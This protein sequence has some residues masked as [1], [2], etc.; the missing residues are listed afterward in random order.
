MKMGLF[1]VSKKSNFFSTT[2][3]LAQK[4]F[5]ERHDSMNANGSVFNQPHNQRQAMLQDP[6]A[7]AVMQATV[8]LVNTQKRLGLTLTI[9]DRNLNK[10]CGKFQ[11]MVDLLR[12]PEFISR[13]SQEFYASINNETTWFK[14]K[15][16]SGKLK[17]I[18]FLL[19]LKVNWFYIIN[20][21]NYGYDFLIVGYTPGEG[22]VAP[23]T[24]TI[25]K[26]DVTPGKVA[27]YF[28][29]LVGQTA[30]DLK[31][32]GKLICY[33]LSKFITD[34]EPSMLEY[35]GNKQG[36]IK[37][38]NNQIQFN[39]PHLIR[40][41]M[42]PYMPVGVTSRQFPACGQYHN[43]VDMTPVFAP[44][45]AGKKEFQL[46][47]L[48]RLG[49]WHQSFFARKD[50]YS[51]NILITKPTPRIP[52]DLLVALLKNTRYDSLD[53]NT[54]ETNI[55]GSL[56]TMK[57][58]LTLF[59]SLI[60]CVSLAGCSD[61]TDTALQPSSP[62]A[63]STNV[64]STAPPSAE[65]SSASTT[66]SS[67]SENI[68]TEPS[69]EIT[70]DTPLLPADSTFS[71]HFIDVG[72]ADA[73]LVECDGHYMLIDGGNKADSSVIYTVLRNAGVPKLDIVVGTH[74][75]EDHIG[76]LPG[77]Y[78]D[79]YLAS[80]GQ[81]VSITSDKSASKEDILTPGGIVVTPPPATQDDVPT[82][83]TEYIVN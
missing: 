19:T 2:F 52:R 30:N 32:I 13:L 82:A 73:A 16:K 9:F 55:Y 41:G 71:I 36:F 11:N 10:I 68:V 48:Y 81:T 24:T 50:I 60:L 35:Y 4:I 5:L 34:P 57:R 61:T 39:P 65:A 21:T 45:F 80:D 49:S 20:K 70:S 31:E 58:L 77:A 1:Y 14:L 46:M 54:K 43:V 56:I 29:Q 62:P 18:T 76:G 69:S 28:P 27:T 23:A 83:G 15:L 72:Q 42:L 51:D 37:N 44:L 17:E 75:H 12:N 79:I 63:S 33:M 25:P 53:G 64:Q 74:A 59:L 3:R 22:N 7:V 40:S 6:Q 47:L 38:L 67:A 66:V 78:G 8:E 26:S